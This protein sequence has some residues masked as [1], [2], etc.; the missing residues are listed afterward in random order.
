MKNN[1]NIKNGVQE[2]DIP[3]LTDHNVPE[4]DFFNTGLHVTVDNCKA[5]VLIRSFPH[6]SQK[7]IIKLLEHHPI[8]SG[9][10]EDAVFMTK[11]YKIDH[12]GVL[13]WGGS[14][15]LVIILNQD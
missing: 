9:R 8:L 6:S 4:E 2:S 11:Y 7:I 14:D 3:L 10:S 13:E 12:P 15:I 5:I 1:Q